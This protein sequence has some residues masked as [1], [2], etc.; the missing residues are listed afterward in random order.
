MT[1][2]NFNE[3]FMKDV[4]YDNIKS[5]KKSGTQNPLSEKCIFGK[6]TGGKGGGGC[7]IALYNLF[8]WWNF[9]L[10]SDQMCSIKTLFLKMLRYSQ[11]NACVGVSI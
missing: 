6:A 2:E 4:T 10:N 7:L 11:E 1:W 3:I 8:S 9:K 5:H